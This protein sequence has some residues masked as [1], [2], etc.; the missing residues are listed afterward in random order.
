MFY[1]FVTIQVFCE[2][3]YMKKALLRQNRPKEV[4]DDI[5]SFRL[6][7]EVLGHHGDGCAR[8]GDGRTQEA[9]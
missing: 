6:T 2:N 4:A 5:C 7:R 1:D 8:K 3:D 9:A